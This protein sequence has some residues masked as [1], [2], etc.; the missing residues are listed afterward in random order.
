MNARKSGHERTKLWLTHESLDMNARKSGERT[1]V[2]TKARSVW[3]GLDIGTFPQEPQP[4]M[5]KDF[6]PDSYSVLYSKYLAESAVLKFYKN[7]TFLNF[8]RIIFL[9]YMNTFCFKFFIILDHSN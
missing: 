7:F 4:G 9:T 5:W 2:W 1:K 6:C 3:D 8:T